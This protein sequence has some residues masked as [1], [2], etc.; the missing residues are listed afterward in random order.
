MLQYIKCHQHVSN[1]T[2]LKLD[3]LRFDLICWLYEIWDKLVF[4]VVA[5]MT[6]LNFVDVVRI[7]YKHVRLYQFH[8]ISLLYDHQELACTPKDPPRRAGIKMSLTS[9]YKKMYW[10]VDK[11]VWKPSLVEQF[12]TAY[13]LLHLNEIDYIN[14]MY[15][16]GT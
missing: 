2:R 14:W 5:F 13:V 12:K 1:L 9:F 16:W 15:T 8:Q 4:E 3:L 7:L 10:V 11:A 6:F